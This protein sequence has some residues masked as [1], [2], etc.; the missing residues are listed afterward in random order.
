V[1]PVEAC[2]ILFG[3]TSLTKAV[4]EKVVLAPNTLR[5]GERFEINPE[6]VVKAIVESEKKGLHFVGLFHSHPAPATPSLVD[7]KF[8]KLWGDAIWLILSSTEDKIAAFQ[9]K[10]GKLEE[11][12][13]DLE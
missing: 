5:S 6:T 8:M 13:L 7:V 10:D 9:M 3:Q 4:V 11:V 1:H 2:G 12:T